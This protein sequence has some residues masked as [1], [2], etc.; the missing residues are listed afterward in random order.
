MN[1]KRSAKDLE[2]KNRKIKTWK[3]YHWY[4][5][6]PYLLCIYKYFTYVPPTAGDML[7]RDLCSS[8][9]SWS[10]SQYRE[11]QKT[12]DISGLADTA[13]MELCLWG[14]RSHS[15]IHGWRQNRPGSAMGGNCWEGSSQIY[16]N[17]WG[18]S[19]DLG[20]FQ[21]I[22]MFSAESGFQIRV[23]WQTS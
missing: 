5:T 7:I 10:Y 22:S 23:T 4:S 11:A 2:G 15:N 12:R 17:L 13:R 18:C 14:C 6:W 20:I 9:P 3:T 16:R 1:F 8:N 21:E 19:V